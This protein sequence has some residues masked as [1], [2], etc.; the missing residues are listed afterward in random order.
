[1]T[2]LG[3]ARRGRVWDISA[4][5]AGLLLRRPLV[6]GTAVALELHGRGMRVPF[7]LFARV[8]HVT[9]RPGGGWLTG[10]VFQRPLPLSLL[11][12]LL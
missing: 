9:P 8:A 12:L 11:R 5:G 10:C 1:V 7:V 2:L 4:R 3:G 6:S